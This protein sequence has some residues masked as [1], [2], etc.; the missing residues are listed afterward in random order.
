VCL[1]AV[2]V[3]ERQHFAMFQ[4]SLGHY[5]AGAEH[6]HRHLPADHTFCRVFRKRQLVVRAQ[7][8]TSHGQQ[9]VKKTLSE[10]LQ[11]LHELQ[12]SDLDMPYQAAGTHSNKQSRD[13]DTNRD[14]RHHY[15]TV[16]RKP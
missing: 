7:S 2:Y 1:R 13:L 6:R 3:L 16:Y 10:Q 11:R 12:Y 14:V 8:P 9:R 4:R 15:C 5:H